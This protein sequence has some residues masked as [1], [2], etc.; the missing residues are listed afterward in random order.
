MMLR[1]KE[2]TG[3][4]MDRWLLDLTLHSL[5]SRGDLLDFALREMDGSQNMRLAGY[6]NFQTFLAAEFAI[7]RIFYFP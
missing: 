6:E 7:E 4:K 5:Q 1:T 3:R 2:L